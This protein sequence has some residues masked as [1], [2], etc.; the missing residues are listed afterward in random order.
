VAVNGLGGVGKTQLVVRYLHHYRSE[1]PDGV[2][3]IR[4]DQET[5]L[6]GDLAS[7]AWRLQ[8][9]ER[10]EPEQERQIEAVLRWMR[11][12]RRW[13]L[14]LDNL[15]PTARDAVRRWLPPGLPGHLLATSRTPTWPAALSLEPLP[16][17]I[18]R[19]FLLERTAQTDVKAANA[20]AETLGCLPLA[21]EQAAAFLEVSS[22]DLAS[23]AN[24]LQTRL[25]ELM[26]EGK[27]ED[28]PH[29]LAST[30]QLSF[31]RME[32][33][34]PPAAVL[35]HFCAF[36][37]PDDIPISILRA[38]EGEVP[39]ELRAALA[40]G[41][42]FDRTIA[43]LRRYSLMER[44]GDGLRVHRLVQAVVRE[45]LGADQSEAWLAAAI[46]LLR[47]ALPREEEPHPEGWP[48]CARLLA[49]AQV[50][51]YL[52]A[53]QMVEPEARSWLLDR[54]GE[55]LLCRGEFGLAKPFLERGLAI[56]ERELGPD[57]PNTATS[58]Q[59]LANLL[60]DQG[61]VTSARPLF[62]RALAIREKAIGPNHPV[63]ASSL[64]HLASLLQDQGDLATARPLFE[65]SLVICETTLGS[66]DARTAASLNDLGHLL[67]E[68]GDLGGARPL[69]EQALTIR[70]RVHGPDHPNTAQS[71]NNLGWAL[72]TER[73]QALVARQLMERGLT[74]RERVLGPDH[75]HTA[76][77]H[78]YLGRLLHEQ[79]DSVA[80]KHHLERALATFERVLGPH[81]PYT[82]TSRRWLEEV[83]SEPDSPAAGPG[84]H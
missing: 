19:Q 28:Y 32:G 48:L 3:W 53:D 16:L 71:L 12:H 23:Y 50:S 21:L 61:Q 43:A 83:T 27:P 5:S 10:E 82:T 42:E 59:N 49:H 78:R 24:L 73:G 66:D 7:L 18:A 47:N 14:V 1:Y 40:D 52:V 4:A 63:T 51:E 26:E 30:W 70:E 76:R 77:S 31:E 84:S 11:Q 39:A 2:F 29:P 64:N 41:I 9:P 58:L 67:Q 25:I 79:G 65:R 80:A 46:R 69:H 38:A 13:L 6:V 36:L 45:S 54:V 35:L 22:R 8:L 44:Q 37:A 62:E 74:I 57:H 33:E 68:Q 34:R 20:V 56:R 17:E 55:Y 15:E 60:R 72:R 81:H 75:P